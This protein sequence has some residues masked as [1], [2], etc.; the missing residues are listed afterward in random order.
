MTETSH[1]D[2]GWIRT[3][4]LQLRRLSGGVV[5]NKLFALMLQ[6]CRKDYAAT[7]VASIFF[8]RFAVCVL[9]LKQVSLQIERVSKHSLNALRGPPQ[10]G[11]K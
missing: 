8:H 5:S 1:G 4:D 10:V 3:T 9:V 11:D 6:W 2:P 7:I